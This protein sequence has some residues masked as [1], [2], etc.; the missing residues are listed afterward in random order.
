VNDGLQD[1]MLVQTNGQEPEMI[2]TVTQSELLQLGWRF[3]SRPYH[4]IWVGVT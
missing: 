4:G 2:F 3:R 1:F